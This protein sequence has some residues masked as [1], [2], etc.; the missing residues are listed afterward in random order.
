M[1]ALTLHAE[2]AAAPEATADPLSETPWPRAGSTTAWPSMP[3]N[4]P[5]RLES[6]SG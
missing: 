1:S 6:V 4:S 2:A 5:R 3:W